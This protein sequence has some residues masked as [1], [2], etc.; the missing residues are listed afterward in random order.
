MQPTSCT[1]LRRRDALHAACCLRGEQS[2]G[3]VRHFTQMVW[4]STT[5][6]GCGYRSGCLLPKWNARDEWK[7]DKPGATGFRGRHASGRYDHVYVCHYMS[8]GNDIRVNCPP[9]K[10]CRE[11]LSGTMCGGWGF[12]EGFDPQVGNYG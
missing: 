12:T 2:I 11:V 3:V 6:I 8:H 10:S 9:G 5:R 4:K 1:R 7:R